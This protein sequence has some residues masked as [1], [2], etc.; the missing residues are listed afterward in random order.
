MP[1]HK[2]HLSHVNVFYAIMMEDNEKQQPSRKWARRYTVKDNKKRKRNK[3][4]KMQIL[5]AVFN[6]SSCADREKKQV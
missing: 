5:C 2:S 3:N 6:C 4:L 1:R